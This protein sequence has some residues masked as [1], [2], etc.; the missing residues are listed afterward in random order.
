[1][2]KSAGYR[3]P[4]F[5]WIAR[6]LVVALIGAVST[7]ST[8]SLQLNAVPEWREF[9]LDYEKLKKLI[10]RLE[11]GIPSGDFP[12]LNELS[13][14]SE[15]PVPILDERFPANAPSPHTSIPVGTSQFFDG[16]KGAEADAIFVHGLDKELD[17]VV[18]FY[19]KQEGVLITDLE[20][21][22]FEFS[23]VDDRPTLAD[24]RRRRS[25][26]SRTHS[27]ALHTSPD[28]LAAVSPT[29]HLQESMS[30]HP[31]ASTGGVLQDSMAS[32]TVL[33]GEVLTA[34]TK[35]S[36]VTQAKSP[37]SWSGETRGGL[38]RSTT[39]PS[40]VKPLTS[41]QPPFPST[42]R[43]SR[44]SLDS[45]DSDDLEHE[46]AELSDELY[47]AGEGET[48]SLLPP[49]EPRRASW[50]PASRTKSL[51]DIS[52]GRTRLGRR[53]RMSSSGNIKVDLYEKDIKGKGGLV[54]RMVNL[55][56]LLSEFEEYAEMNKTGFTKILKKYDK[57][58]KRTLKPIYL[59]EKINTSYP[60]LPSSV[61][62]LT[63]ALERL[64]QAYAAIELGGEEHAVRA[65]ALLRENLRERL[66]W[67]RNTIWRDMIEQERKA[68][69]VKVSKRK[70]KETEADALGISTGAVRLRL[71]GI[72]LCEVSLPTLN[73]AP[74][75]VL[76][77]TV[78]LALLVG[79]WLS[80]VDGV[81]ANN[82]LGLV[83]FASVLWATE[84]IPLFVTAL[85][86]PA[87][88][89][90]L[91]VL[92]VFIPDPHTTLDYPGDDRVHLLTTRSSIQQRYLST[93]FNGT[94]PSG[95]WYRLPADQSSKKVFSD[96]FSPTIMLLL[97]GFALAAALSKHGL[98][99][100]LASWVLRKA[101][102]RP[103]RVVLAV[104]IVS[105]F[106]SMWI[107]NVAAP[108]L[109]FGLIQPI[110]RTLPSK[111]AYAKALIV[112][113]AL[114]GNVGGMS[115]PISSP[116]NIVAIANMRPAPTWPEWLMVSLP[117]CMV[118]TILIWF[119]IRLLFRPD[120]AGRN[121]A[122]PP[123]IYHKQAEH[124]DGTQWFVAIVT[125]GTIAL[126]CAESQLEHIFGDMGVIAIFP[127]VLF[128][129]TGVLT[130]E[131]FNNFLWTVIILAMG[132][133]A[134][135]KS[136]DSSGLLTQI[137]AI[138]APKLAHFDPW[139]C[140]VIFSVIVLV[141][142]TFISHTVGALII[143]PVVAEMGASLPDP[144]PRL[145]VMSM[146]MVCSAAMGLP[147]S[148]FPNMNAVSLEDGFGVPW[149]DVKDFLI[150]GLPSSVIA[151]SSV[152]TLGYA[153]Q[154]W[155]LHY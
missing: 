16:S 53:Q 130:K 91:G 68:A 94:L 6:L 35:T 85:L 95:T 71:C 112:G 66:V 92:R 152:M 146:A 80:V 49:A 81:E 110:L 119:Y 1:M 31:S 109:C 67:E 104:M 133:I 150:A 138:V 24:L 39:M 154:Y 18:H 58:N 86:V 100:M 70:V 60:W 113:I 5:S 52:P 83:I 29:E 137:T 7:D 42:R 127:L 111:S 63:S 120:E 57:V 149:V 54:Q 19:I 155:G 115:T 90:M 122:A 47:D 153:V 82:C 65:Q 30:L 125:L 14:S 56:V 27:H 22:L 93:S 36:P 118:A 103:S 151:W 62:R 99:K 98:A 37:V 32:S 79:G 46:F 106:L 2:A 9:Y 33:N 140:T 76:V 87:L 124:L 136:V 8:H 13:S 28:S 69:A 3:T 139:T 38:T 55:F 128:F 75:L 96:M 59:S 15:P 88:V 134:L 12:Q 107:S 50:A 44:R 145:M 101:G 117:V 108:V 89:V 40:Q 17:R 121:F 21:L 77:S 141:T 51:G 4:L 97:G 126:W 73:W 23:K 20:Q 147:V 84:A 61:D 129:G 144:H 64:S 72:S 105:G 78:V 131:D 10:Y 102:T 148:S 116:Q 114:A 135:G 123:E 11:K 25:V 45:E 48:S 43:E 41:K 26:V 132:G 74:V 34:S 143:L 142:T